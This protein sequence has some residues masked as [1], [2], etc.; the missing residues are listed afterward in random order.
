MKNN[1]N[2]INEDEELLNDLIKTIILGYDLEKL[3]EK[4]QKVK[5]ATKI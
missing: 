1:C 5:E 3:R 4:M 2:K